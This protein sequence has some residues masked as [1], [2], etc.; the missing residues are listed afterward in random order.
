MTRWYVDRTR[1]YVRTIYGR[2]QLDL[3]NPSLR[4]VI[5]R[6]EYARIHYHELRDIL[7]SYLSGSLQ[8]ASII[9]VVFSDDEATKNEHHFFFL[10]I[11][12]HFTACVQSLHAIADILAHALYFALAMN[13]TAKPMPPKSIAAVSVLRELAQHSDLSKLHTLFQDLCQGGSFLHLAALANH[14]KHRSMV[15]PSL[16]EDMTGRAQERHTL[17][18]APFEYNDIKYPEA[19]IQSFLE[20]EYN[21]SSKLVVEIGQALNDVLRARAA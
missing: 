20:P 12:A 16:T 18:I 21:R 10:K 1:E 2:P 13:K 6:R 5:D 8:D 15:L 9:E 4:S 11:G 7:N 3:L 17:T 19:K 14:G